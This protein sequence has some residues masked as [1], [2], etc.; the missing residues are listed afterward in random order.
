ME[1]D[2]RPDYI[3]GGAPRCATTFLASAL[4]RHPQIYVSKPLMPEPKVFLL[5]L[6]KGETYD[7]RYRSVFEFVRSDQLLVEKTTNY[8]EN[9]RACELIA[10]NLPSVKLIFVVRDP[11]DRAYSNY[12]WT[13]KN[14]IEELSF[15]EAIAIEGTRVNP[16][17]P[18]KEHARPFDYLSRGDY[19]T[20]SQRYFDAFGKHRIWIGLF[21]ELITCPEKF[22]ARLLQFLCVKLVPYEDLMVSIPDWNLAPGPPIDPVTKTMLREF[23]RPKVIKFGQISGLDL[24]MWNQS[25]VHTHESKSLKNCGFPNGIGDSIFP[26]K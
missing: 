7:Q 22:F 6:K 25:S 17:G 10:Q 4:D 13:K 20:F 24:S 11:V 8:F 19:A 3:I 18:G 12:L 26:E 16:L 9:D 2:L 14:G 21:E 1:R 5:P 23:F 15:E